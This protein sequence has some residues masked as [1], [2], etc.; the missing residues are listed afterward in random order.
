MT[1]KKKMLQAAAGFGVDV[2][3]PIGVDFDGTNDYLS[4]SSDLVGNADSKTFTISAWVY[5]ADGANS[6]SYVLDTGDGLKFYYADGFK[7]MQIVAEN[8]TGTD[9]LR[10]ELANNSI[11]Y[12]TLYHVL[13]SV[14]LANTSNRY[15]YLNGENLTS[16]VNWVTYTNDDINF[17][18]SSSHFVGVFNAVG[19]TA[20]KGRLAG[21]YLDYTYR[22]LSVEANRRDFIDADGLYVKPPTSGIISVPMD[23]P[24]DVG[25]NDGTGG[26][27]TL[28][29]TVARSGRGPNQYNAVA[30]TFDGSADYLSKSAITGMTDTNSITYSANLKPTSGG[31]AFYI[32][33]SWGTPYFEVEFNGTS[34]LWVATENS[35]TRYEVIIPNHDFANRTINLSFSIKSNDLS[36]AR[37]MI[38]GVAVTHT[39]GNNVFAS[40][41]TFELTRANRNTVGGSHNNGSIAGDIGE[42]YFDTSYIDLATENPFYDVETNK[43]KYLGESGELPTGSS[44]LVYLPLRA[45][46]AGDN[47]GTGGAFTVNSGPYVGARGASEFW[48]RSVKWNGSGGA[49]NNLQRTIST[50]DTKTVTVV[51]ALKSAGSRVYPYTGSNGSK[52]FSFDTSNSS[53]TDSSYLQFTNSV[54]AAIVKGTM[55]SIEATAG[56]WN[57][58]LFSVDTSS[59]SKRHFYKAGASLSVTW[60]TYSANALIEHAGLTVLGASST[61][62]SSL[63]DSPLAFFYYSTEYIDFSQESNRLKFV[64]GLGYPVDLQPAIDTGDIP[65]PL[66]HMKFND[67]DALGTNSGSGGDFT[68]NGAVIAGPDVKG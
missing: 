24:D 33:M 68:V 62:G 43:P 6:S 14:D 39:G 34:I 17:S 42:V 37:F 13:I 65:T 23:N 54:A 57:V 60:N 47:L 21:V 28:N 35:T 52:Q 15:Y 9:V 38:D 4:R 66:I 3:K 49:A 48:A 61:A 50:P 40:E 44:P 20:W 59:T 1:I 46:D 36:A 56:I 18:G 58:F 11:A 30:S 63:A 27:F 19:A 45:D 26:D 31:T 29:G 10:V 12:N 41:P 5:V 8:S 67:P 2:A 16:S 51:V 25:R 7:R 55:P 64:D 32:G 22:D 53:T